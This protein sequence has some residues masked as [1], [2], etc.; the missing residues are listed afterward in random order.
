VLKLLHVTIVTQ[1]HTFS[2]T[3]FVLPHT[4]TEARPEEKAVGNDAHDADEEIAG[5]NFF[6]AVEEQGNPVAEVRQCEGRSGEISP[7]SY[8]RPNLGAF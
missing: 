8:A 2:P 4:S 1:C 3:L 7:N 6:P 5:G